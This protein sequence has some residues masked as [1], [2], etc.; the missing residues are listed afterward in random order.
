[1]RKGLLDGAYDTM[2]SFV[3]CC[4]P[5][6]IAFAAIIIGCGWGVLVDN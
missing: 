6:K 3:G 5:I 1:M 2:K 4:A